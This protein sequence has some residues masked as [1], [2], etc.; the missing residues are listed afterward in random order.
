LQPAVGEYQTSGQF[1][2][3]IRHRAVTVA[4]SF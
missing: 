4:A 1:I 3:Q 2:G